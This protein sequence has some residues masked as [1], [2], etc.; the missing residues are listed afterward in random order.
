MREEFPN[1]RDP[2]NDQLAFAIGL[3]P[4]VSD[5]LV[6]CEHSCSKRRLRRDTFHERWR[7]EGLGSER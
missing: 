5:G 3:L 2:H 7:E 4:E 6:R 1:C